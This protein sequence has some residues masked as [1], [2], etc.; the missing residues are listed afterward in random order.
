[1]LVG[2]FFRICLGTMYHDSIPRSYGTVLSMWPVLV[3]SRAIVPS[4]K[5]WVSFLVAKQRK[6][7]KKNNDNN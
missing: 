3:S 2:I 7:N 1:M 5:C 6:K 4:D